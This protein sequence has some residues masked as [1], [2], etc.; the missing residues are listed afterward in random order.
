[1]NE[2]VTIPLA[3]LKLF[4]KE[5]SHIKGNRII[6]IYDFIKFEDG[7]I[8]K[9]NSKEFIVKETN[10]PFKGTFLVE[11]LILNSFIENTVDP[12][13]HFK[14]GK[15]EVTI[16]DSKSKLRSKTADLKQFPATPELP[17]DPVKINAVLLAALSVAEKFTRETDNNDIYPN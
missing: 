16:Y 8:I 2:V 17:P 7:T 4:K 10:A 11:D 9:T 1:M 5:S 12:E 3:E 14:I 15:D 13:I 6:P